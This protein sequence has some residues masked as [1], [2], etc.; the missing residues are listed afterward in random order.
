MII[1]ILVIIFSH[2]YT[3]HNI[4][5]YLSIHPSIHPSIYPLSHSVVTRSK[6]PLLA[7]KQKQLRRHQQSLAAIGPSL[8]LAATAAADADLARE[9]EEFQSKQEMK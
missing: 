2:H 8:A 3:N 5:C 9:F 1:M 4:T 7:M 6:H